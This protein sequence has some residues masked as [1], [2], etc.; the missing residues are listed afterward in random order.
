MYAV[1]EL[2]FDRLIR[3]N[4]PT[5]RI[6]AKR[7][8][9]RLI[10]RGI[11]AADLFP[12]KQNR[13][14]IEQLLRQRPSLAVHAEQFRIGAAEHD[15]C[16][17]ARRVERRNRRAFDV[18]L[19]EIDE[20]PARLVAHF[21]FRDH[22]REVGDVAVG[23]GH[24]GA[25]QPAFRQRRFQAFRRSAGRGLPKTRTYRSPHR[26]RGAAASVLSVLRCRR[27]SS[28]SVARYTDDENGTG[29]TA[30]PSSSAIT[31]SSR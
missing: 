26:L 30:R 27:V 6:A 5:E 15:R 25:A 24:F 16:M 13:R 9:L 18:A 19:R 2:V 28:A 10:E 17:R 1:R 11:G 4:R 20:I 29:A 14:A 3:R 12:C 8:F 21:A 7:V 23:H 31:H 22:H